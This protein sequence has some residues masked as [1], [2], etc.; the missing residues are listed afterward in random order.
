MDGDSALFIEVVNPNVDRIFNNTNE[1]D[2]VFYASNSN[3]YMHF[4]VYSNAPDR[5]PSVMR[6]NRS[7]VNITGDIV[8]DKR[9][10]LSGIRLDK[11]QNTLSD[12]NITSAVTQGGNFIQFPTALGMTLNVPQTSY[13]FFSAS[14]TELAT[15]SN[16]GQFMLSTNDTSN[17]PNYT[18]AGDSDTGLYHAADNAIGFSCGGKHVATLS[19]NT[20]SIGTAAPYNPGYISAGNIGMFRNRIIN[21]DM[22]IDQRYAGSN[23]VIVS[24]SP[25]ANNQ[26]V[27]T[28]D[29][30]NSSAISQVASASIIVGQSNINYAVPGFKFAYSATVSTAATVSYDYDYVHLIQQNI[31]G[32]NIADFQ[33]GTANA[34]PIAVSFWSRCTGAYKFN[35]TI[36]NIPVTRNYVTSFDTTT[37]WS[38][39][40][41]IIP[42]D[43]QG[44]WN[45]TNSTGLRITI[46]TGVGAIFSTT[47]SN[48]WTG[49]PAMGI[50]GAGLAFLTQ[51]NQN[52]LITGLQI[53][54]GQIA[55]P[56][57]FRPFGFELQLCQRYF[58]SSYDY[59]TKI[60]TSTWAGTASTQITSGIIKTSSTSYTFNEP[61][62]MF[63]ITKRSAAQTV[64]FYAL[65]SA[66]NSINKITDGVVVAITPATSSQYNYYT[67]L[68]YFCL[69]L[70]STSTLTSGIMHG[71]HFTANAELY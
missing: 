61:T 47:N 5:I 46:S 69:N 1:N 2:V 71:F 27:Y 49:V 25:S 68:N 65:T 39:Y 44:T 4:G 31:E 28:I 42:G 9:L 63:K 35:L 51:V 8:C 67:T 10:V 45:D 7:N 17:A 54:K 20:M 62:V 32:Y 13:K 33:W 36:A 26:Y 11:R 15:L 57:E 24:G 18:W 56:F 53:E 22:R 16:N 43:T 55:T 30:F 60:G 66:I 19:N 12:M 6:I 3:S 21:G 58:E 29:R 59:G 34:A 23:L 14:S 50:Q 41:F 40:T 64:T 48:V 38:Y 70:I 37:T 52:F